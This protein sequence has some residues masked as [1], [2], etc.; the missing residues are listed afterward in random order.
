MKISIYLVNTGNCEP[1]TLKRPNKSPIVV[2]N[3]INKR[4]FDSDVHVTDDNFKFFPLKIHRNICTIFR[5]E[6]CWFLLYFKKKNTQKRKTIVNDISSNSSQANTASPGK[7]GIKLRE[8]K[9]KIA[10]SDVLIRH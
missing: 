8:K 1:I 3:K 10:K 5:S 4:F 9:N 6:I 7:G 2:R